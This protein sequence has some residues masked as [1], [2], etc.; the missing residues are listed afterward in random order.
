MT[1]SFKHHA[2]TFK[3]I[4]QIAPNIDPKSMKNRGCVFEAIL[5]GPETPNHGYPYRLT[6]K[7]QKRHPKRHPKFDAEKVS[8]I[9]TKKKQK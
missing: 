4:T 6:T 9:D 1:K 3:K 7:N 8:N 2:K 5:G